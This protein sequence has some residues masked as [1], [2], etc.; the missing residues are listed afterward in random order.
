MK[1]HELASV[2]K[3]CGLHLLDIT[4]YPTID[5]GSVN[6]EYFDEIPDVKKYKDYEVKS[7]RTNDENDPY[8]LRVEIKEK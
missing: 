7:I 1:L 6:S 5:C 3:A 4:K 8:T 2:C